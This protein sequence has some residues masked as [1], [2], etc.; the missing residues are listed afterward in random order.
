[1]TGNESGRSMTGN[2]AGRAMT[3]NEVRQDH[4]G[5]RRVQR[6]AELD[7]LDP[8][9]RFRLHDKPRRA[10]NASSRRLNSCPARSSAAGVS[11]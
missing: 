4:T 10:R 3:G 1:M 7:D 11:R 5:Q 2:E 8:G 6:L 9:E